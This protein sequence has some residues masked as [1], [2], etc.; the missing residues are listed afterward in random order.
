MKTIT[1]KTDKGFELQA[2]SE[3]N[4][5]K[6]FQDHTNEKGEVTED[7]IL[8]KE[9]DLKTADD[10]IE[11][12]LSDGSLDRDNERIEPKGWD[13]EN[14]KGNPIVLWSH[15]KMQPSIGIM[16]NIRI[17]DNALRGNAKFIG[18]DIDEF[19]WSIGER[20][21]QGFL[22]KGSV[23]FMPRLMEI[24]VDEKDEDYGVLIHKEQEL[25][26]YSIVNVPALPSSGVK[27]DLTETY[28]MTVEEATVKLNEAGKMYRE[29]EEKHTLDD[30]FSKEVSSD[31][32]NELF[33]DAR[34]TSGD[35]HFDR[36]FLNTEE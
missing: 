19:G 2:F 25:L 27:Q 31:Y 33:K 36:L 23:G 26:E 11:F 18:K 28:E 13:L 9:V 30:M 24:N 16:E 12:V 22:K 15:D 4:Y 29:T 35:E 1:V 17:E 21:R 10:K 8:F 32:V 3:K 34:N 5:I 14:Y 6:W 20:V 7:V